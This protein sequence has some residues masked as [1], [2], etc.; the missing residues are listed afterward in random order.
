MRGQPVSIRDFHGGVNTKAADALVATEECRNCQNVVSTSRGSI[1]K[2]NGCVTFSSSF[3]GSPTAIISLQGI[4]VVGPFLVA[5]SGTKIHSITTGGVNADITGAAASTANSRWEIIEAPAAAQGPVYMMNGIDPALYWTGAGNVA[6]WTTAAGPALPNGQFCIYFKNKVWVAGTSANPSRLFWSDVGDPRSFP[7][8]NV[9]D[10]DPNDGDVITGLGTAGPYLLVFKKNKMFRVYDLNTG[11]NDPVSTSIG[12]ASHRSIVESPIGTFFLSYD[13]GIYLYNGSSLKQISE[14]ITPT[15]DGVVAAN[16][17]IAAGG[18]YNNHYYL[19]VTPAGASNNSLVL[20][21][22]VQLD[23]WWFHT[24]TSNQ[25]ALWRKTN[26]IELYSAQAGAGIVDNCY[27]PNTLQDNGANFNCLWLGPWLTMGGISRGHL[28]YE[29][30]RNKRWRQVRVEG[31]GQV[32]MYLGKDYTGVS[33]D[34]SDIFRFTT[35]TLFGG[36]GTFGGD[37]TFGDFAAQARADIYNL[38]VARAFSV[39]FAAQTNTFFEV[40]AYTPFLTN[41]Q[42]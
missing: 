19:C 8:A 9:V 14:R 31:S 16:K 33:L 30:Y 41:R 7:A 17:N 5:T 40:D 37:G 27:V 34:T 28:D 11:A 42:N 13:K 21:Y 2:R 36:T 3:T 39:Q 6:L 15:V 29:P 25:F 22:D 38:G 24:N 12:A 23:S 4:E 20:D 32:D 10:F 35:A 1:K 18:Y 26:V